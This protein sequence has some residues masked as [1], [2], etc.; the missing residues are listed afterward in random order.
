MTPAPVV[1]VLP[2]DLLLDVLAYTAGIRKLV[3]A[4]R[5]GELADPD[6]IDQELRRIER[7]VAHVLHAIAGPER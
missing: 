2:S 6:A 7:C 4:D 3:E 1:T 5:R